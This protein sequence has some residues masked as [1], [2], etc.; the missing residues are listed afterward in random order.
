MRRRARAV[1][2]T[3]VG[4]ECTFCGCSVELR[5]VL[6]DLAG[7]EI[8]AA[9]GCRRRDRRR[10]STSTS[11][12][13]R[14]AAATATSSPPSAAD[15]H[16]RYVD[17][18]LA[19]LEL[20]AS[21]APQLETIFLGGGTPTFTEPAALERLLA[22]L[23]DAGEV[24]VEA[25]PE[26]VTP[27]LARAAAPRTASTACRSARR[28]SSPH[29]L[30]VLERVA[31]PDDVRR[32][33]Y[34]LR[35]AGF[36]NLSLDLIYGIPGQSAADLERDLAEALALEPE[37]LS[38][39]ELEAKPGTRFTHAHGAELERQADAMES[40]FELVVETLTG[41][42]LPLVRDGELLPRPTDGRAATCAR[43]TTSATGSGTTTSGSASAPSARSRAGAG[44][45]RRR[46]AATSRRSRRAGRPPR[47]LE[48][49]SPETRETSA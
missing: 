35:D 39:Y 3:L 16:A 41:G 6:P 27:E 26:T 17:A 2:D 40:Y 43:T 36:D 10:I 28:A 34:L 4:R 42:R 47:E 7:G 9:D 20:S 31:Q 15:D 11:R 18:L 1:A 38:A 5:H 19:E 22:A 45:T 48:E 49:L 8:V 25:N 37:H 21:A 44:G 23:P 29:L 12:S 46:S 32:A 13:A 24:T 33:F 30:G 14:T